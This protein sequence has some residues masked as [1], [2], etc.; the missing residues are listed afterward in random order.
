MLRRLIGVCAA[1]CL[2]IGVSGCG[3]G[4][5]DG[6]TST[7]A[8]EQSSIFGHS[9]ELRT[10]FFPK[11]VTIATGPDASVR[12]V[13]QSPG[14]HQI[15]SG[16]LTPKGSTSV[17]RLITINFGNFSPNML[18]A[19]SGDTIEVSN[20]S[21]RQFTMQ[22]V[23]DNG[24]V[25]STLVFSIGEMKTVVFPGPGV[26]IL[27]DPDS[28]LVATVTLYGYPVP[29]GQFQSGIMPNGGVFQR[30]FPMPGTYRYYDLDPDDPT[31]VYA[32]GTV[33]VQ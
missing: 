4:S 22:I 14:R 6:G 32:S 7:V 28:Q 1:L 27:Q 20:L 24:E 8:I 16:A 9:S 3:G 18:N 31:H 13:N 11:T 17:N 12:W 30:V 5:G 23:N 2:M 26:W 21:G 29:D 33:V 15:V 19:D 10:R 25:K